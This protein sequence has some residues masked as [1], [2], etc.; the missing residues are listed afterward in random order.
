MYNF[1]LNCNVFQ[2][3][4]DTRTQ[5]ARLSETR[6]AGNTSAFAGCFR[7][8]LQPSLDRTVALTC[9]AHSEPFIFPFKEL[10]KGVKSV[11]ALFCFSLT[12]LKPFPQFWRISA[13]SKKTDRAFYDSKLGFFLCCTGQRHSIACSRC[14]VREDGVKR[15]EKKNPRGDALWL[16]A[17]FNYLSAWSRLMWRVHEKDERFCAVVTKSFRVTCLRQRKRDL[18]VP[19]VRLDA[20]YKWGQRCPNIHYRKSD[21]VNRGKRVV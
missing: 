16:R 21:Q 2:A 14:S 11:Q 5:N 15:C 4:G 7:A 17:A 6:T 18:L 19:F 20:Q 1:T 3:T 9:K 8:D 12:M 10:R 13:Y